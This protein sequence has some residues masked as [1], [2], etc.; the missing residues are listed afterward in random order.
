[1]PANRAWLVSIRDVSTAIDQRK[2][3]RSHAPVGASR[4]E[5]DSDDS[6]T[7]R[8]RHAGMPPCKQIVVVIV[9]TRP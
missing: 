7:L 5:S 3:W 6:K 2:Q 9:A 4:F 1:M 8:I